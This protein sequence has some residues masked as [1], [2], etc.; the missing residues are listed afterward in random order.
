MGPNKIAELLLRKDTGEADFRHLFD[1]Q[2]MSLMEIAAVRGAV[3][4]QLL[5]NR[6]EVIAKG[7]SSGA[8]TKGDDGSVMAKAE[9]VGTQ[10]QGLA[11]GSV[12]GSELAPLVPQSFDGEMKDVVANPEQFCLLQQDLMKQP[13]G[14]LVREAVVRTD[15]LARPFQSGFIA[16][17]GDGSDDKE[18]YERKAVTVRFEATRGAI[19]DMAALVT[20]ATP[21]GF[22]P[23]SLYDTTRQG[24][25]IRLAH[26]RERNIWWGDNSCNTSSYD[27]Y[28]ASIAGMTQ[29]TGT[30]RVTF[31]RTLTNDSEYNLAGSLVTGKFIRDTI[32]SMYSPT[33]GRSAVVRK[34]YMLPRAFNALRDEAEANTRYNGGMDTSRTPLRMFADKLTVSVTHGM[35]VELIPHP[36]LG[37]LYRRNTNAST[38]GSSAPTISVSSIAAGSSANSLFLSSDAGQY[39]YRVT[40]VNSTGESTPATSSA[41]SVTAGQSVSIEITNSGA[42]WFAVERS[43]L[44]GAASTSQFIGFWKANTSGSGS[45]SLIVDDNAVRPN[46]SPILFSTGSSSDVQWASLLPA[47]VKPLAETGTLKPFLVMDFGSPFFINQDRLRIALNAGFTG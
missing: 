33:A 7:C 42:S 19:S 11:F 31:T 17:G 25:M 15:V 10:Q 37:G 5:H 32:D 9:Y 20:A 38:G 26:L 12:S 27:G 34:V 43:T 16:E 18:T 2:K 40:G 23:R 44:N 35:P 22:V 29:N 47:T 14:G 1:G 3:T 13:V 30:G 36:G 28:M 41:V 45:T 4:G 6:E 46:T 24:A 8:I 39:I 21:S